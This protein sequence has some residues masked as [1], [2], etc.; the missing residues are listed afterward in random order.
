MRAAPNYYLKTQLWFRKEFAE[1]DNLTDIRLFNRNVEIGI[2]DSAESSELENMIEVTFF[3]HQ[4][5][6]SLRIWDDWYWKCIYFNKDDQTLKVFDD[7]KKI[8]YFDI[9]FD[10]EI[11]ELLETTQFKI[12]VSE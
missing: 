6:I 12:R 9:E 4:S 2:S 8:Y 7:R 10:S 3:K 5:K 1:K 11:N